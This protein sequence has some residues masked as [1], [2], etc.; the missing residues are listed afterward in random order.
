MKQALKS[1]FSISTRRVAPAAAQ[2]VATAPRVLGAEQIRLVS[3]GD[4]APDAAPKTGW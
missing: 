4:G 3:G 1:L 2:A